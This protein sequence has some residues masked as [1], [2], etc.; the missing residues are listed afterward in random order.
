MWSGKGRVRILS[1]RVLW[2]KTSNAFEKSREMTWTKG[3]LAK[4]DVMLWMRDT[5]ATVVEPVG[6]KANWSVKVEE[7]GGHR[8]R[9]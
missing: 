5:M 8:K 3:S 4:Q 9:G 1:N 7:R 2:R 6:L